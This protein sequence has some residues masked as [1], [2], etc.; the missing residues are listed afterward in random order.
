MKEK[1]LLRI[2]PIYTILVHL[3]LVLCFTF[4][5]FMPYLLHWEIDIENMWCW[6]Y[7]ICITIFLLIYLFLFLRSIEW[8][9]VD[10]QGLTIK[11]VFGKINYLSW[12]EVI[13][14]KVDKKETWSSR[15]S[16]VYANWIIIRNSNAEQTKIGFNKKKN[17]SIWVTANKKNIQIIN[18]F[19]KVKLK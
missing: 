11:C 14:I 17:N 8:G 3:F 15:G 18:L 4:C 9:I 5:L 16:P 10:K 2:Q 6:I 7:N 1:S 12:K 13:D 19:A